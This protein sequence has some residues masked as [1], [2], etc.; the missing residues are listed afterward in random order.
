MVKDTKWIQSVLPHR[1]PFLMVDRVTE[2]STE[3]A[4][5]IKNVTINEPYFQGHFPD[6][7]I[8]PGVLI[9]EA[10]AQLGGILISFIKGEEKEQKGYFAGIDNARFRRPVRPG[11]Q[12]VLKVSVLKHRG[13][14]FKIKG[15]ATV[16]G[17]VAAEGELMIAL[18]KPL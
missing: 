16:D 4:V 8:V 9:L 7:P 18:R 2:I 3:E 14:I 11:D 15:V 12:I 1:Y 13:D 10:L 6:E 17:E 5:G